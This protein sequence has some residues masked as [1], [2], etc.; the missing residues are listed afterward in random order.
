MPEPHRVETSRNLSRMCL[1]VFV[2]A[3]ALFSLHIYRTPLYAM[4]SIQYMGNALLME[5]TN[6][7]KIHDRVYSDLRRS[8]PK[9]VFEHL[10]GNEPGAA[11]DQNE[12]RRERA[13]N[14]YRFAE[15]LPLFAIRPL[16]NQTLWV[17]SKLGVG[18]VRAGVLISTVSY[19]LL[20]LLL[21]LWIRPYIPP[22]QGV[23]V[24]LLALISPNLAIVGRETTSD[25]LASLVAFTSLY[26][27]FEKRR[28]PLGMLA[29]LL[30]I[31]FRTDFI[32]LAGPVILLCWLRDE[33]PATTELA[34]GAGQRRIDGRVP[35]APMHWGGRASRL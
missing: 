2:L 35:R 31:Y 9:I 5:E 14:P 12:S 8:V 30:S 1:A 29:L 19:F 25:A 20:G 6:V 11:A 33:F 3:L 24:G 23:V 16:Y 22:V 7:V 26:L 21:Y 32:V 10:T 27:I 15:F 28:L 34:R 4:D 18:L 13:I 17:V